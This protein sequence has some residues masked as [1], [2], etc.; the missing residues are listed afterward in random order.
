M[1]D[2]TSL[3]KLIFTIILVL[4]QDIAFSQSAAISNNKILT[5]QQAIEDYIILYSSLINY[6][7]NPFL[8]I[9]EPELQSYFEANKSIIPDNINELEFH[10]LSRQLISQ[11]K[12]GHTFARPSS[13]WYQ[14]IKGKDI[15]LP[16]EVRIIENRIFISNTTDD[17]F[18]F[19]INDEVLGINNIQVRD[20]LQKMSSMQE[21]DGLT[22]SFSKALIEKRFRTYILFLMGL[23][24][25][26]AIDYK[27]NLG[28]IKKVVVQGT[29]KKLK[30]T[31][32]PELPISFKKVKENTWSS[33]SYDSISNLAYLKIKNFGD[34]KEFKKQYEAVFKFLKSKE[35]TELIVDLRDNPGGNFKNGNTL[36]TYLTPNKFEL[37]FQKPKKIKTKNDYIK[38][39]KWVKWTKRAFATKPTK[40]RIK[41][42]VS[43]TFTYK[44]RKNLFTGKINVIA[45]GITFS[46]AALVAAHLKEYGAIFFGEETGGAENGC[47][48]IL[49][50]NLVLPNSAIIVSI[51][52][53]Q[54]P[55]NSTKAVFG[56]GVKPNYPIEPTLDNST[57]NTLNEVIKTI[58]SKK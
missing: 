22:E 28:E 14:F 4:I 47:N 33:F 42:K 32:I 6:H 9:S 1:N 35:N 58:S 13:A 25:E 44:P 7:P 41:G 26:Y 17:P 39:S 53:Y 48:G 45:N 16:F 38:L 5:K 30:D 19:N 46:Q 43:E 50:Y 10:F 18:E 12:C 27:N 40:H 51:P 36:L 31:I 55:S 57:D 52:I 56:Y 49:T 3:K 21:R 24:T 15:L 11:I 37:N 8:Y 29:S 20:I 23:Q 54:V 34:R 2:M